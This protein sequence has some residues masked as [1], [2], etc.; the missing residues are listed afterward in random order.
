MSPA[1]ADPSQP[2]RP[3][4]RPSTRQR[5]LALGQT[6][7]GLG[8]RLRPHIRTIPDFPISGI[9]FKD[10]APMLAQPGVLRCVTD[11]LMEEIRHYRIEF[12]LAID[13]R[14]FVIGAPLADRLNAGFVMVRKPGK[15]PGNTLKFD[16]TCEYCT[17]QLEIA[18][19][20]IKAGARYLIVDDL[21]AT[22][23]T[24]RAT[25][26]FAKSLGAEIA[27]Y[28]F[29]VELT[30]LNGRSRLADADVIS[31]LKY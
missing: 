31:L 11:A 23:G 25:A 10:V 12:V 16:Y 21:L 2:K 24:T 17:G 29:L 8:Q 6:T 18:H 19:D 22:G 27:A 4:V 28:C 5:A 7:G 9:Q 3:V 15:L 30:M 20:A 14:G 1:L 13:A 26:D